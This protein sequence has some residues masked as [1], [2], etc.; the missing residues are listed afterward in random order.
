MSRLFSYVVRYDSGFAPNPF[1]GQCTLA[2]CKPEIRRRATLGDWVL[3]SGSGNKAVNRAG[4]IVYAMQ[5]SEIVTFQQYWRD[6]RFACK[7]PVRRGSR[8]QSCGDNIYRPIGSQ[9]WAQ[10]DS[11]HSHPDGSPN[12]P[13]VERDTKINRVLIGSRFYYFGG[14]GP[15]LPRRFRAWKGEDICKSGVGHKVF[16]DPD[17]IKKLVDWLDSQGT[18]YLGNPWDW[19]RERLKPRKSTTLGDR[20]AG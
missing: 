6:Q 9:K 17:M 3:G 11:F 2:T 7:R 16:D 19:E 18:G 15:R 20:R 10:L 5:I 4:Y 13:H 14:T 8:K 1:Y 12:A